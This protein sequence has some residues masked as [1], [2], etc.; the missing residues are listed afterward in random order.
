VKVPTR[1]AILSKFIQSPFTT[2]EIVKPRPLRDGLRVGTHRSSY[3][4]PYQRHSCGPLQSG[5]FL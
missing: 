5:N 2:C 3:L 4:A 1:A